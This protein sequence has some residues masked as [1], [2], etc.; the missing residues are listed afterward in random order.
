MKEWKIIILYKGK[1]KRDT[2]KYNQMTEWEGKERELPIGNKKY[3]LKREQTN[4]NAL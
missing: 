1:P 3:C 2:I 4:G